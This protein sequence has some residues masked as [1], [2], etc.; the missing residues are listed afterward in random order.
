[1]TTLLED[2]D[3]VQ[4]PSKGPAVS[5]ILSDFDATPGNKGSRDE[6]MVPGNESIYPDKKPENKSLLTRIKDKVVGEYETAATL[7]SGAVA[8]PIG[9]AAGI[10]KGF[11]GGKYGTAQGAEEAKAFAAEIADSLT[12]RPRSESGQ[13]RV[14]QIGKALDASKLAGMGPTE[15]MSLAAVSSLP[16]A[17]SAAVT[18][19]AQQIPARFASAGSAAT[20]TFEQARTIAAG[21]SP[22]IRA[23]VE[24]AGPS[25][26]LEVLGRHVQA[27][28][29]PVPVRLTKGQALQD[30]VL[31]SHEQNLRG[32]HTEFV[33][34][35]EEQNKA[36]LD[37]TTAIREQAAPDVYTTNKV[38]HGEALIDAYK[39]KDAALSAEITKRYK[40]LSDANG[41]QFPL[42]G[43]AFV[44]AAEEALHKELLFDHVPEGMRKTLDR[45]KSGQPMTFENFESLRT[46][47]ARVQRSQADG[48][49]KA[50]AGVIR[51]ALEDM[52][53]PAG[54]ENLKPLAD[55]ARQAARERFALI[56]A[57]PAYKAVTRGT[58]SADKFVEKYIIGGDLK[59]VQTMKNN[60]AHD[61][62]AQQ[63]MS[64][65]VIDQLRDSATSGGSST[66]FSQAGYN[67]ALEKI[68]PKLDTLFG[69]ESKKQL[70]DL[71]DVARYTQIQP[72]GSFVNNSNTFVGAVAEHAKGAAEGAVNVAAGGVPV[73]SWV[74]KIG[75]KYMENREINESLQT[76]AGIKLKDMK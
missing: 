62:V 71:G 8:A 33:R 56:E 59:N 74:R 49:Q 70:Q 42:D 27:D 15:G 9:A 73:G 60:L 52:P 66:N 35:Y 10:A 61:P 47:L 39:A 1:M 65:G 50:A 26:N 37:N 11:F 68:R 45:L 36:L 24:K 21:A 34:R 44:T 13:E 63:T 69:P 7:G 32:K 17:P 43:K 67:K 51:Q 58:A 3:S 75:G 2:F 12:Y 40:A 46:N 76:G 41:G 64:A 18:R 28:S 20:N 31:I 54:A 23:A 14:S 6:K 4:A 16:R 53:M 48:N 55:S 29:L 57:D 72:R 30:P 38:A 22:E 5:S 25:A 19:P